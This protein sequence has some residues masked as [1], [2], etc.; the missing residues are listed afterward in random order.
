MAAAGASPILSPGKAGR[1]PPLGESLVFA[2]LSRERGERVAN[3]RWSADSWSTG[4]RS[5]FRV[6][7]G[8]GAGL[9]LVWGASLGLSGLGLGH[10]PAAVVL[11]HYWPLPFLAVALWGLIHPQRWNSTR[12]FYFLLLA[13]CLVV[14]A[15][16]WTVSGMNL[17]TLVWASVI[18]AA[19][20]WVAVH[21]RWWRW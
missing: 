19:A 8:V 3:R 14:L 21:A 10:S 17:G 7:R 12:P 18:L 13:A 4:R 16:G 11:N 5:G 2:K 1:L 9:L 6:P 15:S 20:V